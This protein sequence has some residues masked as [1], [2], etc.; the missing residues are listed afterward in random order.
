MTFLR[1]GSSQL[2]LLGA[3][4]SFLLAD[5]A[6]LGELDRLAHAVAQVEQLGTTRLTTTLH[7]HLAD[8]RRVQRED[9]LNAFVVHDAPDGEHLVDA[10]A[11]L[12][13]H[14]AAENLDAFFF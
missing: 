1:S 8:E 5:G 10:L 9:T 11:L 2:A 4:G 12:H 3:F 14:H 13:E 6:L 7:G